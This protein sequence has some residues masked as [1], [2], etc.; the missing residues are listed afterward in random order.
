MS[1]PPCQAHRIWARMWVSLLHSLEIA[2]CMGCFGCW[3]KTPGVCVIKDAGNGL[4]EAI[5]NSDLV[6]FLTPVT[7]GSYSSELKKVLDRIICLVSPFFKKIDGEVHHQAR[8]DRYP[9]LL[10]LGTLPKPDRES[11]RIF[12]TLVERNAIS[13]HFQ[14]HTARVFV[15]SREEDFIEAGIAQ[16]LTELEVSQ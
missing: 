4:A 7:F 14:S 9:H 1:S 11:E 6:V 8:Y 15:S 10:V 5:L 3:T 12:S 2:P 13:L 16:V